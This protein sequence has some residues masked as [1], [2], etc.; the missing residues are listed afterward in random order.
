MDTAEFTKKYQNL[1]E[2]LEIAI[3]NDLGMT[4]EITELEEEVYKL[5]DSLDSDD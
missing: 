4:N 3:Q 5:L 1:I 2:S